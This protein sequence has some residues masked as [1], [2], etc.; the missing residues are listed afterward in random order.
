MATFRKRSGKWQVQI[1]IQGKVSLSKTFP[2]KELAR[3]WA[4]HTERQVISEGFFPSESPSIPLRELFTRYQESVS[5]KKK[6]S[7]SESY[8][9]SS[10]SKS[11]LGA[12][13]S[14]EIKIVD[15]AKYRDERLKEVSS[16]TIRREFVLLRH[17]F[18]IASREWGY[19]SLSK[20]FSNF[21]LPKE[22]HHR[23]RRISSDELDAMW[24][25]L[26][27]QRNPIY[28]HIAE[29]A[30][31]TGMR[32]SELLNIKIKDINN[33]L[34][35]VKTSKSG[36]PRLVPLTDKAKNTIG[37]LEDNNPNMYLFDIKPNS[38]RLAWERARNKAGLQDLRFHDLRHEAIS[39]MLEKGLSIAE[40]ATISGHRDY[41]TLFKYAHLEIRKIAV[42]LNS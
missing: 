16:S 30:L 13:H 37:P 8:R 38:L 9:L 32:R 40:V 5:I 26:R 28:I 1:R 14:D 11:K 10:L 12:I 31:E 24:D 41:K 27:S 7:V 21:K 39:R 34:I 23:V 19:A 35:E 42:K 18:N 2:T 33:D 25:A 22:T 15:L 4:I 29:L 6:S 3:A 36:Y 17:I 20:L